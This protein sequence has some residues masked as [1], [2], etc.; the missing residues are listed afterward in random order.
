MKINKFSVV[1]VE[2]TGFGKHDRICEIGIV[3]ID[4]ET[5][6]II[7]EFETLVNPKRDI[8]PVHIHKITASMV[9]DAPPFEYVASGIAEYLDGSVLVAHNISFDRR[10]LFQEFARLKAN[11]NPGNGVC[12]LSL[13]GEKLNLA[14]KRFGIKH[15]DHHRAL[16]DARVAAEIFK[17][18]FEECEGDIKPIKISSLK[19]PPCAD[20]VCRDA[21][22]NKRSPKKL[23]IEKICKYARFP[24]SE[25]NILQ[26]LDLLN[27]A[28]DDLVVTE[29]ERHE[30]NDLINT[31]GLTSNDVKW[32]NEI[33]LQ[34][35]IVGAKRDGIITEQEK[36]IMDSVAVLLG[37]PPQDIPSITDGLVCDKYVEGTRVCFTGTAVDSNNQKIER[38]ILEADAAKKGLQPV[39]SVTKKGCDLV[40]AQDIAS[41]STKTQK[42]R[43][44]GIEIISV[45]DFIREPHI[46]K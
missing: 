37:L 22:I 28:L 19:A 36:Q 18:L 2:T 7:D 5:L 30:I 41:N 34:T 29:T 43:S 3:N 42:A 9:A 21:A 6:E 16:E 33:Y 14:A 4:H 45:A 25:E 17:L 12:T 13:S 23:L 15:K 24:T 11:F 1:D 46:Y 8:G 38:R 27:S 44:Y 10:M 31:L 20:T 26:Y 32:A 35:L 40:V 39:R